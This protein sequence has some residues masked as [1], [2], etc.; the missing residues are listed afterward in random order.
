MPDGDRGEI[1]TRKPGLVCAW[2]E[3]SL[4]V[5]T[6][7]HDPQAR[8]RSWLRRRGVALGAL[9]IAAAIAVA[10][11][12][13]VSASP[14]LHTE[15]AR[16]SHLTIASRFVHRKVAVTLVTPAGGGADRPLL[17]FLH[18]HDADNDSVLS[19]QLFTAMHALGQSAPDIAFPYGDNS[20]WHNR[21]DGAWSSYVLDEVIPKA[22]KVLDANPRRVA[23]GGLSMGGFGAYDLARLDPGRFCAIGGHSPAIWFAY[24]DAEGIAFDNPR[25]FAR[26][27]VIAAAK[28]NPKLYGHARLWLDVGAQDPYFHA[29]DE[30]LASALH[31]H[32][33]VWPGGHNF[34]YWN[35]HWTDYL[36]F[37]THALATCQ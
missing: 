3:R 17:V 29:T 28:A 15:G 21:A 19:D 10:A 9:L 27:N 1:L 34:G 20:Y 5:A 25:D 7:S 30:Q 18:G 13:L 12:V 33:H 37:Y 26:N 36:R 32:L 31:I 14:P 22:L 6:T 16:I 4:A 8:S 23:I 24:R 35:A 2:E 11:V